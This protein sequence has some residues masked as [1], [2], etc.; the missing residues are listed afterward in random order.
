MKTPLALA[1]VSLLVPAASAGEVEKKKKEPRKDWDFCEWISND[2]GLL[3]E[4]KD[5][6][7]LNRFQISGRFH[8]QAAYVDGKDVN[9]R[10]FHDAYDEYRRTR[11]EMEMELLRYFDV[12]V[13][14]NLVEDRRFRDAYP[15]DLDW[16]YDTFDTLAMT[17]DFDKLLDLEV[18]DKLHLTYG[19][20]KLKVGE[21]QHQSSRE[22]LTIER[23]GLSERLGGENSRPT[24]AV[25]EARRG[26]WQLGLGVFSSEDDSDTLANW[27]DGVF[28]YACLE[29]E[30]TKRWRF[31]FDQTV[32]DQDGPDSALG[33]SWASSLSGIYT[34]K[35]WGILVNGAYGDNG[36]ADEGNA[37]PRRQGDFWGAVIMPWYWIVDDKLQFVCSWQYQRSAELEGIRLNPRYIG[38]GHDDPLIN[39]R[40]V[41]G[42]HSEEIYAG[43]NYYICGHH[44]KLMGGVT[45]SNLDTRNG[46]VSAWTYSIAFRTYF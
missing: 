44:A 9:G 22:I 46:E 37:N 38:G 4:D 18:L 25:L 11:L 13:A 3:H 2:A 10:H 34:G 45:R 32:N 33:Y 42:D 16:G 27:D 35:R 21:E 5:H 40:N 26:D 30:P 24:G 41:R 6:W 7:L 15:T 8:Y 14:V 43:L 17:V 12:E 36:G 20:M 31:V 23:S 1:L 39:V 29:W 19:R 28:Y